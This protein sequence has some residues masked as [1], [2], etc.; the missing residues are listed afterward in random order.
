[1]VIDLFEERLIFLLVLNYERIIFYFTPEG[2]VY[3]RKN[4][5]QEKADNHFGAKYNKLGRTNSGSVDHPKRPMCESLHKALGIL[6][7]FLF[8]LT[9][10]AQSS[11]ATFF[12]S[13]TL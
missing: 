7:C 8:Y 13:E 9:L 6:V 1:M 11:G 2:R 5:H 4:L 12:H 10:L 3:Y